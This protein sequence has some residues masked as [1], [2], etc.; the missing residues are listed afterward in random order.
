M[1]VETYKKVGYD[2]CQISYDME[3]YFGRMNGIFA[4]M[5]VDPEMSVEDKDIV[6]DYLRNL[7]VP[8]RFIRLNICY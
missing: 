4:V 3:D 7:K 1:N 8:N 5:D 2:Q 6:I